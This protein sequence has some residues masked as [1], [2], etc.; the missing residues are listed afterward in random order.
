M[1]T[2]EQ[3][4]STYVNMKTSRNKSETQK[5]PRKFKKYMQGKLAFVF[6]VTTLALFALGIIVATI[7][8]RDNEEYARI[9]LAQ[10][11]YDSRVITA[12]RGSITDRN[13]T[14]LATNEPVYNLILDPA[15]MLADTN[16]TDVTLD[17][18]VECFGFDRDELS[19]LIESR[20]TSSYVRYKRQMPAED[21][22]RFEAMQKE[23]NTAALKNDEPYRIRG[24]WFETEYRRIYPYD[25]LA[26]QVIGFSGSDGTSGSYGLEQYY[27]EILAG[28]NGREYGYL[29]DESNLERVTK[30]AEDGDTLVSTIDANIQKI[31][32]EKIA[33]FMSTVGAKETAVIAMDPDT[34]E[35][36]GM[37]TSTPFDLNKPGDLSAYYTDAQLDAGNVENLLEYYTQEQIDGM[38]EETRALNLKAARQ[39]S[40]WRNYCISETIEPGSTAKV[41]TVAAGLE[42]GIISPNDSFYCDGGEEFPGARPTCHLKSGHGMLTLKQSLMESCNDALMQIGIRIGVEQFSKYQDIFNFG[43]KTGIDLPGE[44]RGL[45]W[46]DDQVTDLTLATESFGQ[47]FNV[48]MIQMAAAYCSIVNGG[49]YYEPHMVRQILDSDGNV[50]QTISPTLVRETVS[51][52]TSE[53]IKDALLATVDE[54]TGTAAAIAGYEFAG[55]TGTAQKYPREAEKYLI[56]F[57]G[58]LPYDNPEIL[59]YVVI[60][61]PNVEDQSTGGYGTSLTKEIMEALIPYLNLHPTREIPVTENPGGGEPAAPVENG[62][63]YPAGSDNSVYEAL[64]QQG[65]GGNSGP[66]VDD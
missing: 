61:E 6:L 43:M 23:F 48:T 11:D 31:L 34:G 1:F 64:R 8:Y 50:K 32:E 13:G 57:A 3:K 53:F 45:V 19:A 55:K 5:Q 10:Q 42:E 24:V 47:N 14:V 56:S 26:S 46:E 65:S 38:D 33:S 20:S 40:V 60:D 59:I 44:E 17:A 16:Y 25:S 51:A 58:F 22:E 7:S 66:A 49:Y 4:V 30:E 39:N 2:T 21:K 29:S 12:Q 36:L 63:I 62:N 27:N 15:V 41:F 35:I 18:L 9:V 54:G 28:T 52:S 37:A